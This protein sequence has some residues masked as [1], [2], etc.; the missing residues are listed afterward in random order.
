MSTLLTQIHA[1]E[2][3]KILEEGNHNKLLELNKSY[4]NLWRQQVG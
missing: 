4:A 3:G 1:M 2:K